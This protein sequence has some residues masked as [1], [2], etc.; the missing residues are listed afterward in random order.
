VSKGLIS[1]VVTTYNRPDAL[2]ATIE[3]CF[4]QSDRDFEIIIADDGSGPATRDCIERLQAAA[5]LPLFHVWQE[6][7]GFRASMSRNR[8]IALARG[9]YIV[10]LD[11]DCVP[12][13]DFL[14]RHRQ[15]AQANCMVTGSRIL[16][17]EATTR[18][19][20]RE[21]IALPELGKAELLRLRAAGAINK[22]LPLLLKLPDAGRVHRRFSWRRIKSCNMAAWR[23][24]LEKVNG[25]DE[26]FVGWGHEDADLAV[27]LHNAGVQR[28]DGAFATEVFHLWH[29]EEKRDKES[30][31]RQAVLA[32][33]RD[34]TIQAT[35]GLKNGE[36]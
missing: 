10:M 32:R 8:G 30:S 22:V 24:D 16:V 25:F 4:A 20:L 28:K 5:P 26:S 11:G 2:T 18:R 29:R 6:D 27:R 12:Q 14:A 35:K 7:R 1:L 23:A 31:N 21:Q 3:A 19:V 33:E 13:H 34:K 17:D 9:D 36:R 15:L